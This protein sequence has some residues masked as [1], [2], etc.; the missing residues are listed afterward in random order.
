MVSLSF[1][2]QLTKKLEPELIQRY[3]HGNV[4]IICRCWNMELVRGQQLATSLLRGYSSM[5]VME[6]ANASAPL[7]A[8]C[9]NCRSPRALARVKQS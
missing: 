1:G 9:E 7:A 5:F 8:E 3:S 4:L 6:M 2:E